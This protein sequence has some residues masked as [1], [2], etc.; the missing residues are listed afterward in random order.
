MRADIERAF[1]QEGPCPACDPV[2]AADAESCGEF[3][4]AAVL[5]PLVEREDG[6]FVHLVRRSENLRRHAGQISFPGGRIEREDRDSLAAALREAKEEIG[7]DADLVEPVGRLPLY[8]TGTGYE[9]RPHVAFVCAGF[10]PRP[11]GSEIAYAFEAPLA[12][13][14]DPRNRRIER[15]TVNGRLRSYYAIPWGEH[16]IW[17][18][19]AAMLKS[20]ADKVLAG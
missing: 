6:L 8:R 17:G 11:D 2:V 12:Y 10:T 18:A 16:T 7:L 4:P 3:T 15:R 14:L 20:F 1:R 13:L 5:C 9:I 19:T